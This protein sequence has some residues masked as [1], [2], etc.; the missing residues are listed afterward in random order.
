MLLQ[1]KRAMN[2]STNNVRKYPRSVKR[3]EHLQFIEVGSFEKYE[4]Q[5]DTSVGD[6]LSLSWITRVDKT[7][8]V[9]NEYDVFIKPKE[10]LFIRM[11]MDAD[12]SASD[13][14]SSTYMINQLV[15]KHKNAVQLWILD[16]FKARQGDELFLMQ[17]LRLLRCFPYE[18][19]SPASFYVAGM[20][21][22]HNSD[23]V[24]SEALSLLDH[25]GNMDVLDML[26]NFEPPMTPWL[27]MKYYAIKESIEKYAILQENR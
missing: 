20:G 15:R 9:Q 3:I 8:S 18:F 12:F 11:L 14:N 6:S 17:L 13:Y 26:R 27:S 1:R 19:L 24:K 21:V 16:L 5:S 23:F 10:T 2:R 22:H 7:P 25:W 4:P